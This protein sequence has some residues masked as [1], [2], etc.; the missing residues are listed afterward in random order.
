MVTEHEKQEVTKQRSQEASPE[1][2]TK[3]PGFVQ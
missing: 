2:E 1:T 3:V